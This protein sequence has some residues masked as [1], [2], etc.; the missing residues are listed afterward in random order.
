VRFIPAGTPP[1]RGPPRVASAHRAQMIQLAIADNPG[2]RLDQRE[3]R[4]AAPGY[5]YD[6]LS[7]LRAEAGAQAPLALI[8]G[9]DQFLVF[10]T[11]YRWREIPTLAHLIV[12]ERPGSQTVCAASLPAEMRPAFT[13]LSRGAMEAIGAQPAGGIW[14]FAM[15][16]L[17]IS[18]SLIRA[19]VAAGKSVRY[20][21][22]DR[23]LDYIQTHRLY[24]G[25]E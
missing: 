7:E 19:R 11:W 5:T 9:A 25:G 14:P 8:I 6:T 23:V 18:A 3:L 1:H 22:P 16:A 21:L 24:L 20:L 4:K 13:G 12:A 2:F 15:T 10:H 17:E